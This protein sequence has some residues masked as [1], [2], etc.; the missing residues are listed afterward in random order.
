M[1]DVVINELIEKDHIYLGAILFRRMYI[2]RVEEN[3]TEYDL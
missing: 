3:K 1:T 2:D